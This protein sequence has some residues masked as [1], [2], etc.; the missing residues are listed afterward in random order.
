MIDQEGGTPSG[1][2]DQNP[3]E[4]QQ[5]DV[6]TGSGPAPGVE[7]E[8]A[9]IESS[10]A[11]PIGFTTSPDIDLGTAP[12]AEVSPDRAAL[13]LE[14]ELSRLRIVNGEMCS[15][16]DTIASP[17]RRLEREEISEAEANAA[18][19]FFT[20]LVESGIGEDG[21]KVTFGNRENIEGSMYI[22]QGGDRLRYRWMGGACGQDIYLNGHDTYIGCSK[23][24]KA[25]VMRMDGSAVRGISQE[26]DELLRRREESAD[27]RNQNSHQEEMR[28]Y[29]STSAAVGRFFGGLIGRTYEAPEAPADA[30][31]ENPSLDP[32]ELGIRP[33][34]F[35]QLVDGVSRTADL[36]EDGVEVLRRRY[37]EIYQSH[38]RQ[39]K[40]VGND[41]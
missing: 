35:Q 3:A 16:I 8:A 39:E 31:F 2:P 37:D 41:G 23:D 24:E 19:E 20:E 18:K 36:V 21:I 30:H 9:K 28:Q 7:E 25:D 5:N 17:D 12:D 22:E 15:L 14:T 38:E 4:S 29:S 26:S 1:S 11:L 6:E 40:S 10:D 32:E 33:E 13:R 27:R 34:Q